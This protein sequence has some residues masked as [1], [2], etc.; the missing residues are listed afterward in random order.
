MQHVSLFAAFEFMDL[1]DYLVKLWDLFRTHLSLLGLIATWACIGWVYLRKRADWESKS[2]LNQVNFSL[3]FIED[4]R[5]CLRTLLELQAGDV[6]LNDYGIKKVFA[7][8]GRTRPD[9]PFVLLDDADDMGFMQR[10]VLNVLSEKFAD[11]FLARSMGREVKTARFVFAVTFEDF[12]DMRTRKFRVLL[13]E[14]EALKKLFSETTERDV[15]IDEP[16]HR[17]RLTV[18]KMMR[19]LYLGTTKMAHP[20]LGEV[21]L[22]LV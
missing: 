3:N 16:R 15:L 4:R 20:V 10:A 14:A 22:G 2:F 6:W 7:A 8:A 18:L 12:P 13:V 21:E 19:D 9:Q 5:L 1:P 11:A 17:D